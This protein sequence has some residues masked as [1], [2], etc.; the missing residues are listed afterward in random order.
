MPWTINLKSF[1]IESNIL[2]QEEEII[3]TINLKSFEIGMP[4]GLNELGM[5]EL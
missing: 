2:S 4:A 3:W 1:E 5:Y